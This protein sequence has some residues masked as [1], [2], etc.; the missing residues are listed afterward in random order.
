MASRADTTKGS[1]SLA[2]V[3]RGAKGEYIHEGEDKGPGTLLDSPLGR[4]KF[5]GEGNNSD[6]AQTRNREREPETFKTL[7]TSTRK[8]ERSTSFL[9]VSQVMLYEKRWARMAWE[10]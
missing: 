5:G 1:G 8:L 6:N 4:Y 10:M 3:C 9:V 2:Y 7:G